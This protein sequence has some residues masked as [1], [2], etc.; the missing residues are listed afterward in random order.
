M[1]YGTL[2]GIGVGPGDPE[3]LT[4]KAVRVLNT[5]QRLYA[6][7]STKNTYSSALGAVERCLLFDTRVEKLFF[8]M[9]RDQKELHHAWETNARTILAD[10]EKGLSCGFLTLGDPMTYSTFGY[11]MRTL[12]EIAPEVPV[13]IIPG[14]TSYHAA[15]AASGFILA[16]REESLVVVSGAEGGRR[17]RSLAQSPE[18]P[19]GTRNAAVLKVYKNFKDIQTTLKDLDMLEDSVLVSRCGLEGQTIVRD[20]AR[21]S[22]G[23][24]YF[25]LIL[26]RK[27]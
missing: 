9:T 6:A 1:K 3:L 11:L 15:A 13:E 24:E 12:R 21:N 20:V 17:L 8:P 19:G 25:S 18:N 4:L 27:G 2:Y 26:A 10:L 22:P 23:P 14:I 5:V 7:A 16:E